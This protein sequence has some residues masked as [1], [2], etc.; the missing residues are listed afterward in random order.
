MFIRSYTTLTFERQKHFFFIV[1]DIN[2][3]VKKAAKAANTE[4]HTK[5]HKFEFFECFTFVAVHKIKDTKVFSVDSLHLPLWSILRLNKS[6]CFHTISLRVQLKGGITSANHSE[7]H[8]FIV[9]NGVWSKEKR[10]LYQCRSHNRSSFSASFPC[11][12]AGLR[13][14]VHLCW[15]L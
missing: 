9:N 6:K 2:S 1:I 14:H 7:I 8:L 10:K 12:A 15:W 4:E 3:E 11:S 5:K 13:W